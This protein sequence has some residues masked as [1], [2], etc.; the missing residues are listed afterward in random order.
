MFTLD[1]KRYIYKEGCY[2]VRQATAR[3]AQDETSNGS[4]L[5]QNKC[6]LKKKSEIDGMHGSCVL[7]ESRFLPLSIFHIQNQ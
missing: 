5:F 4:D 3:N 1:L 6:Y 7:N 2:L